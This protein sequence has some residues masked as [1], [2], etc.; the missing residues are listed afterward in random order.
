MPEDQALEHLHAILARPEFRGDSAT[1]WWQQ[2]L[3]PVLEF[4][5]TQ[6]AR[7]VQLIMD[8]SSGREGLLGIAVLVLAALL[9]VAAGVYLLRALRLS[10]ARDSDARRATLEERREQSD[11][12]WRAAQ[13]LASNGQFAEATRVLYLSALYAL[14]ERA[15]LHLESALTNREHLSRLRQAHP[16]VADVFLDVVDR[17]ERVRYGRADVTADGFAE[18]SDHAAHLRSAALS[19]LPLGEGG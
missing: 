4:L 15:V 19:P 6:L 14:D 2:M 5:W 12:L 16:S 3:S 8:S 17:Y 13:Q 10:V 11:Q 9:L 7:L 18:F 1:P